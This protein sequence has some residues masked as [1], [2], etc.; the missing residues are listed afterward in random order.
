MVDQTVQSQIAAGR[1][2]LSRGA[3]ASAREHFE[4]AVADQE[5]AEA[6]EGLGWAGWWLA[7]ADLTISARERAYRAYREADDAGGAGRIAAWLAADFHEFRG[8]DAVG[9]GWLRR[10]HRMLD[11]LP[12]RADHG[13][14]ALHEGSY[15]LNADGDPDEAARLARRAVRLGRQ[16]S[17]LDLEA[18]G[19]ALEGI[20]LV[21]RGRVDAGMRYLDE[22]SAIVAGEELDLPLSLGWALCYLIAASEGVGDFSRA[23][24]WCELM[25]AHS[26]RWSARQLVGVCRSSYGSVLAA[27]G[28]WA[29]AE[30][31]LTGAVTDLEAA[32]PGMAASGF[33]RLA[34][35]RVRQGRVQEA[36]VLFGRAGAHRSAVLGLGSLALDEGDPATAVDAAERVLR[37][38]PHA[39]ILARVPALELLVSARARLGELEAATRAYAELERAGTEVGTPYLLGRI[40]LAAAELE[41]ARGD[42]EEARRASEDAIDCFEEGGAA[43]DAARARLALARA[44][45]ELGRDEA[46]SAEARAARSA[47]GAFGVPVPVLDDTH[48]GATADAERRALFADLTPREVEVLQLVA[49]GLGDAEIAERLM[50]SP[51]TVHRHVANVRTKLRLPSRAAAVAYAARAGLL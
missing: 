41:L 36:R 39:S 26:E 4:A 37:K 38:L 42:E 28:N 15:A 43:Y 3:W 48:T 35:L 31:E 16:F 2:A 6:W 18:V 7:D 23:A 10:A 45:V 13:W 5:S 9:R 8:E 50:L 22:S 29:G 19:L 21:L 49:E 12:E 27:Q 51:H 24:Q 34:E 14:L 44:L 17:V 47:L 40:R 46:A 11:S 30:A 25:R 32:R 1:E 20:A 33:V